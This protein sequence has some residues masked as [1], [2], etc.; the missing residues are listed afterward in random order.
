M[1]VSLVKAREAADVFGAE[2]EGLTEEMV[3]KFY[4]RMAKDCHP[5]VHGNARLADWS[6]ISWAKEALTIWLKNNPVMEEKTVT[7][8]GTCRACNGTG[9][10]KV[11]S[12]RSFGSGLTM[13]CVICDGEGTVTPKEID[14]D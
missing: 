7:L 13:Q 2:L 10:V 8:K 6:R 4:R 14:S 1:I 11:N 3:G 12:G 9:R 5:D